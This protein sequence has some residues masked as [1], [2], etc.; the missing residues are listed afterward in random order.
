MKKVVSRMIAVGAIALLSGAV[1]PVSNALALTQIDTAAATIRCAI[2]V[3]QVAV[4]CKEDTLKP[5]EVCL[6][7]TNSEADVLRCDRAAE[8]A[9]GKC[10]L[11]GAAG[12]LRCQ[13]N[14]NTAPAVPINSPD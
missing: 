5:L 11:T 4:R 6:D 8:A 7:Q 13:I 14:P 2:S 12:D 1:T 9:L 3:E 10:E